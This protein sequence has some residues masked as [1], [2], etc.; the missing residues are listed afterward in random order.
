MEDSI[1]YDIG[2]KGRSI[3][4]RRQTG[5]IWLTGVLPNTRKHMANWVLSKTKEN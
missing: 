5:N 2:K 4:E 3:V 1:A